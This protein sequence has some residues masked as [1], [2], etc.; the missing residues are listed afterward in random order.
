[1][2]RLVQNVLKYVTPLYMLGIFV[3]FCIYN[4]PSSNAPVLSETGEVFVV[5]DPAAISWQGQAIPDEIQRRFQ[6][7]KQKLPAQAVFEQADGDYE[8]RDDRGQLQ[9][10]IRQADGEWTVLRHT[11]GSVEKIAN[12]PVAMLSIAVIVLVATFLLLLVHIARR[13]WEREGRLA[14]VDAEPESTR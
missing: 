13:R 3:L 11:P 5:D 4:V 6:D 7:Y 2:P 14:A 12:E 1:V 10:V 9:F 8:I